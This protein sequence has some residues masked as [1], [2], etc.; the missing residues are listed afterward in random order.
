[1]TRAASGCPVQPFSPAFL[2]DP[3]PTYDH[4]RREAPVQQVVMPS[5][6]Q[7][8]LVTRYDD[9]RQGLADSRLS[10]DQTRLKIQRPFA[11]L[12]SKVE[13]ALTTDML[14]VDPPVHTRL[15]S[16]IAEA[17]TQQKANAMRGTLQRICDQLL[18]ELA[19]REIVDVV[20]DYAGVF[21]TRATA[22]LLGIPAEYSQPFHQWGNE[23]ASTILKKNNDDELLR[24]AADMH[25]FGSRLIDHK[26][27][28]PQDDLLSRLVLAHDSDELSWEELAS[29][30][31]LLLIAGREGPAN[32]IGTGIHLLLTHP[33]ELARLR[34]RPELIETAVEEFLRFEAPLGLAI[35]RSA[36]EPITL[37]GVT[38]PAG[39]PILFSL[40]STG[41]D[42]ERFEDADDLDV[43]RTA[44]QHL[45]FGWG[46]HYCLGAP[47]GRLEVQTAI[48]S[49]V[50]KFPELRPAEPSEEARWNPSVIT[51]GLVSLRV[52]TK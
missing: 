27:R 52:R 7:V 2:S 14:N 40:L 31:N 3:H 44:K 11:A 13:S 42:P 45:G 38:I 24:P 33:R 26:R 22:A 4:L 6:E 50:R 51:R 23:I 9:V 49:L 47:L 35:Y 10:N 34:A 20:S 37:S 39:E 41:R 12:P 1:M 32:M 18:E 29:M 5:G 36:D 25:D 46:R 16:V 17:F 8:W 28:E 30:I 43:G 48:G 19:T 15:R 21:A